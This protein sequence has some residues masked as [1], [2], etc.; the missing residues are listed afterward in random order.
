M[1]KIKLA[2]IMA[3]LLSSNVAFSQNK[4]VEEKQ[5]PVA[6]QASDNQDNLS[7][8]NK[9]VG[10]NDIQ[11]KIKNRSVKEGAK[12][13]IVVF[14]PEDPT[15]KQLGLDEDKLAKDINIYHKQVAQ[16]FKKNPKYKGAFLSFFTFYPGYEKPYQYPLDTKDKDLLEEL[17]KQNAKLM[18]LSSCNEDKFCGL[19]ILHKS[20]FATKNV[21]SDFADS[22]LDKH[23][24]SYNAEEIKH[25]PTKKDNLNPIHFITIMGT[26][27]FK[28][29]DSDA[30]TLI[31][32]AMQDRLWF[33]DR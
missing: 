29:S 31:N 17:K 11:L 26:N 25:Y 33:K 2:L 20:K 21:K 24:D 13:D 12:A 16:Y 32:L 6:V 8:S 5:T 9:V 23:L 1:N 4:K 3:A 18:E 22:N 19:L 15:I 7:F 28:V 27:G 14:F 30:L 10:I